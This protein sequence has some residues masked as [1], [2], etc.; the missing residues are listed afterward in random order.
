MVGVV[1]MFVGIKSVRF[2]RV[3]GGVCV[4][5]WIE[6]LYFSNGDQTGWLWVAKNWEME[7]GE[8]NFIYMGP[9]EGVSFVIRH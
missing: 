6:C 7:S 2:T 9:M 3:L 4:V 5:W 8:W 1:M